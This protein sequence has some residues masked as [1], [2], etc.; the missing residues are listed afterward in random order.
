MHQ[1]QHQQVATKSAS[2]FN[3]P[4]VFMHGLQCPLRSNC[5]TQSAEDKAVFYFNSSSLF[6]LVNVDVDRQFKVY[7]MQ[8]QFEQGIYCGMLIYGSQKVDTLVYTTQFH[9]CVHR[10]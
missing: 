7:F 9:P 2:V 6:S 4:W 10:C 8:M 1:T 3:V 5:I